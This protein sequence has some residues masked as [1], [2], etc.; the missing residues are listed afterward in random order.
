LACTVD[1]TTD[2]SSTP[3]LRFYVNGTESTNTDVSKLW[4][5]GATSLCLGTDCPGKNAQFFAGDMD[6]VLLFD[7]MLTA[8]E[9]A[10]LKDKASG[11][12]T[13]W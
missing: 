3:R 8:T 5:S 13:T 2:G 7:R 11:P 10:A 1:Q 6:S 4:D 9:V 12:V